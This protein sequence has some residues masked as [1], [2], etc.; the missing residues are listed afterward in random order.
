MARRLWPTLKSFPVGSYWIQKWFNL[1][2]TYHSMIDK[3]SIVCRFPSGAL[4]SERKCKKLLWECIYVLPKLEKKIAV[5]MKTPNAP[6]LW[7][8]WSTQS[9]WYI[10]TTIGIWKEITTV[11]LWNVFSSI[12]LWNKA[13]TKRTSIVWQ[14]FWIL[15]DKH[16]NKAHL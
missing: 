12:I 3:K 2:Q 1:R 15:F 4:K 11:K 10:N 6:T 9:S 16:T 13:H 8:I 7:K 5:W 14:T